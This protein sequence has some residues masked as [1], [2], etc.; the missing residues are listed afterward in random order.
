MHPH[1]K[2]EKLVYGGFGPVSFEAAGGE[3]IGIFG[4]SGCGKTRLLRSIADLDPHDGRVTVND[5]DC[6][7]MP[8]P[9]WRRKVSFLP[10]DSQW[11]FDSVSS[12][13]TRPPDSRELKSLGLSQSVLNA[14]VSHLSSGEKQRLALLRTLFNSPAVL[15]LDE[16]TAHLDAERVGLTEQKIIKLLSSGKLAAVWVSH[17]INQL[18][19]V[20][21]RILFMQKGGI[22]VKEDRF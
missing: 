9:Q 1:L 18:R 10:A 2:V 19:R 4:E 16:V 20:C 3:C 15:L 13:F 17:N 6:L 21:S 7:S 14:E 8:A 22:I 12:H 5:D 11:W